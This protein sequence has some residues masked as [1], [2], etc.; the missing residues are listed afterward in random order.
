MSLERSIN[1]ALIDCDDSYGK[2]ENIFTS[3]MDKQGPKKNGLGVKI[4]LK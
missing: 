2:F 3:K 1:E 4:N